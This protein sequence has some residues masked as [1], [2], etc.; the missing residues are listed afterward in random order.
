[1]KPRRSIS[2]IVRIPALSVDASAACNPT[3]DARYPGST[4][5]WPAYASFGSGVSMRNV[6]RGAS[7]TASTELTTEP[8]AN[9]VD[10]DQSTR[11]G[12]GQFAP[13]WIEIDLGAPVAIAAIR[14]GVD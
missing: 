5:Y 13:Q 11:W 3:S 9:A 2:G 1:M 8:A 4:R 6:A 10:G 14:L 12:S 7:V